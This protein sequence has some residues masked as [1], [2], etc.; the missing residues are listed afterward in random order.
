MQTFFRSITLDAVME[1]QAGRTEPGETSDGRERGAK[2][3]AVV[4][5][6]ECRQGP[7][8]DKADGFENL[9]RFGF[10]VDL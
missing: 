9:T 6:D 3:G 2:A 7:S 8:G 5:S 1:A 10:F 4:E